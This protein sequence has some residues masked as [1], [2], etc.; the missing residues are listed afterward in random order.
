[1]DAFEKI[2][3]P[4]VS[5]IIIVASGKG[6]VGKSTV[7]ANLAVALARQGYKVALVDADIYGPSVP[8]MFGIEG[9]KPLAD[10]V[11]GKEVIQPIEKNGVKIMSI[12]FF[13]ENSQGL[14]WRG[15]MAANA[16]TQLIEFTQWGEID[17]MIIDFP[18]GTG[19]IQLTAVQKLNIFG[20]I[21]VT[22]PQEIALND[23]RKAASMFQNPD[24]SIP[25]LGVI[26]NMSWFTPSRHPDEKYFIFGSGGGVK[27]A[28]ECKVKMLGQIPLVAEVGEAA[29]KG[30]CVFQQSNTTVIEAFDN[31]VSAII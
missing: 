28:E 19:D 10:E 23:A 27:L 20:A 15:P 24:I 25:V 22:T 16:I 7:S 2:A 4:D 5:K 11:D 31:I 30:Q 12:G 14:I 3:L 26:E 13:I 6:G 9:A 29:E 18:P 8:R 21:L 1:M 17:F